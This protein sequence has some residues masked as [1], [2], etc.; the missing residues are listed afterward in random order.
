MGDVTIE[1]LK[2]VLI[3]NCLLN[4]K[5]DDIADDSP[6][7]GPGSIGLDSIDALQIVVAIEKNFGITIPDPETARE[8][9]QSVATLQ[10][11][12]AGQQQLHA[13]Q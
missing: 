8:V 6:L 11:W 2:K 1:Q 13:N 5:P 12:I 3:E 10:K 9:M 4:V 7:F